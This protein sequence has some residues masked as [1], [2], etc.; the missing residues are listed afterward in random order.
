MGAKKLTNGLASPLQKLSDYYKSPV[1]LDKD[2]RLSGA[3][4][5]VALFA[6]IAAY[7][8]YAIKSKKIETLTRSFWRSTEKPIKSI[9]PLASW[10]ILTAHLLLEKNIRKSKY[11]EK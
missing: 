4:A 10:T 6:I 7:D 11:G 3:Y 1:I 8:Y 9:V 5:W 2:E